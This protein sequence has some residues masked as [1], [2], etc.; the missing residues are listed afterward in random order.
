M[1]GR[2]RHGARFTSGPEPFRPAGR[3][4]VDSPQ[5]PIMKTSVIIPVL[6][7][8]LLASAA[9][10]CYAQNT[11]GDQEKGSTGWSGG[12]KDQVN[13]QANQNAPKGTQGDP[14]DATTGQ[15]VTVHDEAL[16]KDQGPIATGED[17]KGPAVQ[18]APSKTPE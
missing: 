5:E 10:A 13:Q 8:A 2:C 9:T 14:I 4:L 12:A 17:L 15:K 18:L 1:S 16:A 7:A 6:A 11:G 3:F